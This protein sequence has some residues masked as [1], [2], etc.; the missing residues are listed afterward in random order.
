MSKPRL[1]IGIP[2]FDRCLT[3]PD[4]LA[5]SIVSAAAQ[6]VPASII[7]AAQEH[8]REC[9]NVCKE[10]EEHPL[11]RVVESPATNLWQN[12]RFVA[13]EAIKDGAEFFLWLQDDDEITHML[14]HRI[15][16][17]FDHWKDATV[18][19]SN[20]GMSYDNGLGLPWKRAWGPKVP[21]DM[22]HGTPA[23]WPGNL[24]T[25][26]GYID[27]WCLSPAKAFRVNDQFKAMLAEMPDNCDCYTE[28]LNIAACA[29]GRR[30][31]NDPKS[32]GIWNIHGKNESQITGESQP[33]QVQP[34]FDYLDGLM[35]LIPDWRQEFLGWMSCLGPSDMIQVYYG[36]LYPHRH[37]S[38]YAMQIFDLI[39]EA[40]KSTG[41]DVKGLRKDEDVKLET[42]A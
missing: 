42:A 33:A 31:I 27:S 28:R 23:A 26:V 10:W 3:R 36:H 6:T 19:C 30:F 4:L 12:W 41:V 38:P 25:I 15:V 32:A 24:L 37:K 34:A 13:E 2:T 14:S 9:R 11:F 39:E 29:I 40:L 35:D 8:D 17:A 20:L 22:K 18:Y 16:H 1:I 7:V 5:K 21:A